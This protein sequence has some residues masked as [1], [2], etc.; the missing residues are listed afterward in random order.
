MKRAI[1]MAA[2]AMAKAT[3]M[4]GKQQQRGQLQQGWRA[5]NSDK[6][7]GDGNTNNVGNGHGNKAGKQ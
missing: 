3:R 5:N 4:A 7:G 1:G 2:R 6:S